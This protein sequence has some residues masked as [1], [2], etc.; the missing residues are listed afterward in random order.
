MNR[1]IKALL[2]TTLLVSTISAYGAGGWKANHAN[3]ASKEKILRILKL[4]TQ[5]ENGELDGLFGQKLEF[6][7]T[8]I[9]AGINHGAVF[10][11]SSTGEFTCIKLWEKLDSTY[12]L[13]DMKTGNDKGQ[14]ASQCGLTLSQ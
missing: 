4:T 3:P 13:T 5:G 9:V 7:S 10:Q 14:V 2:I 12:E 8:Q 6:Y 1:I 11:N